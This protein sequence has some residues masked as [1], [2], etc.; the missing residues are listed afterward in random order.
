[1]IESLIKWAIVI[2][3]V[4]ALIAAVVALAVVWSGAANTVNSLNQFF[5]ESTG[6]D[7]YQAFLGWLR[8]T[9]GV[10]DIVT[11]VYAAAALFAAVLIGS[12]SLRAFRAVFT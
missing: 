2:A 7:N 5:L 9:R 6:F 4:V 11:A 12:W 3:C 1:M 10:N 8:T